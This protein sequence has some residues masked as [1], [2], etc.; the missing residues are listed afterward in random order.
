MCFCYAIFQCFSDSAVPFLL[1]ALAPLLVIPRISSASGEPAGGR[2]LRS[3][4]FTGE[5]FSLY[6]TANTTSMSSRERPA[7][8]GKKKYTTGTMNAFSA[9]N[10][11]PCKV[12]NDGDAAGHTTY[13]YMSPS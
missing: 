8:S 4:T 7:V 12:S 6:A 1:T 9:A 11:V 13:R 10:T 3:E 2:S 5:T